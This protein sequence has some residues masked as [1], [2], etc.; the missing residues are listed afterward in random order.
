MG[1]SAERYVAFVED[2]YVWRNVTEWALLSKGGHNTAPHIDS[3]GYSTWIEVQEGQIGF[4]W[5][6]RPT[7]G[8]RDIWM[9]D[10]H[11]YTG[12]RWRY[13]I[14]QQGDT[15]FFT[16]GTIHFVFRIRER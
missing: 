13:V 8:E 3:H 7:P 9:A 12:G 15:V 1:Q 6:S 16:S 2:W 14:L 4:G 5:M 11:S 10:P